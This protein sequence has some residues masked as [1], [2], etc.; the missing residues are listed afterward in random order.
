MF[1]LTSSFIGQSP[2]NREAS[3]SL[4]LRCVIEPHNVTVYRSAIAK[5]QTISNY[6]IRPNPIHPSI[7][8]RFGLQS[9]LAGQNHSSK[10]RIKIR[11]RHPLN[12]VRKKQVSLIYAFYFF[13]F[14]QTRAVRAEF[15]LKWWKMQIAGYNS[16]G[17][18]L[19]ATIIW[20]AYHR[21]GWQ[22]SEQTIGSQYV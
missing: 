20:N 3:S 19:H 2:A 22:Q 14:S 12:I 10:W 21:L 18:H 16:N 6:K 7:S 13:N 1:L 4:G 8:N 15:L 11:C 5:S 17:V 9:V